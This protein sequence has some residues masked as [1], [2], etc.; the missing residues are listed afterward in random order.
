DADGKTGDGA[1][2]HVQVPQSFFHEQVARSGQ[3]PT[4]DDLAVGMIFLPRTDYD[5]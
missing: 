4:D 5:A 1:G 2:I 3:K